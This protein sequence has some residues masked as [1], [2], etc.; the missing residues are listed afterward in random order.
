MDILVTLLIGYFMFLGYTGYAL[1]LILFM[2][3][4]GF[5]DINHLSIGTLTT[6][7]IYHQLGFMGVIY[8]TLSII[9]GI[10]GLYLYLFDKNIKLPSFAYNALTYRCPSLAYYCDFVCMFVEKV[11]MVYISLV[12]LCESICYAFIMIGTHFCAITGNICL[13]RYIYAAFG[14]AFDMLQSVHSGACTLRTIC[15]MSTSF[16]SP[17]SLLQNKSATNRDNKISPKTQILQSNYNKNLDDLIKS[18]FNNIDAHQC[19]LDAIIKE[20]LL[21]DDKLD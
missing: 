10:C 19:N 21:A 12:N 3:G 15:K 4:V 6:I 7:F 5:I 9:M 8:V 2:V 16:I 18:T 11:K 20:T 17:S 13:F 14:I 1:T